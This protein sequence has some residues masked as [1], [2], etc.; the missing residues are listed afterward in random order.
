MKF[1][2][3]A[4]ARA[5]GR[6]SGSNF[7][8]LDEADK[9]LVT[10]WSLEGDVNNGGFDQYYFNSSGDL[11]FYAPIAL[12][13]IGAHQMAKITDDANELF[14]PEGPARNPNEREAQL[15]AI[16]PNCSTSNPWDELDRAF[17]S[18]PDDIS[19]LLTGFLQAHGRVPG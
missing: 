4:F 13:S 2:D 10:I 11:A 8:Q 3:E 1:L 15:L 14:G 6:Y 12:R 16:A 17:Y 19:M 18:Y 9:V 7:D 5:C